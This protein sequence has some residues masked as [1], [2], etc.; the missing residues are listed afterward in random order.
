M[1]KTLASG[2][3]ELSSIPVAYLWLT[4]PSFTMGAVFGKLD[5]GRDER[6]AWLPNS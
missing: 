3:E 6:L 4:S 5:I 2:A 1:D